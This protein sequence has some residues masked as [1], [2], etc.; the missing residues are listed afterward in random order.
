[1]SLSQELRHFPDF[2][3][4]SHSVFALP[5]ALAALLLA[6]NGHPKMRI[7]ILV[8]AALVTARTAAM[9]FNRIVDRTIDAKNPRT[10]IRHIPSGTVS[11]ITAWIIVIVST[12]LFI[13]ISF[14]INRLAGYL[15]PVALLIIF[16]Y[17]FTK[18]FTNFSH[19]VLGAALGLAPIG[20]WV[21]VL[22]NLES[23]IPWLIGLAVVLWVAGFDIIYAIQDVEFDR[24]HGL[25]SMV[26]TLGQPRALRLVGF[27]HSGM[28]VMLI[29]VGLLS[30]LGWFYF[31][32]LAIVLVSLI[33][34]QWLIRRLNQGNLQLAFL[35]ANAGASF[36][37]LIAVVMGIYL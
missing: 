12:V 31:C 3:K 11:L 20:A 32:G 1:M 25:H 27:L 4:L 21:A 16:G 23:Y 8:I 13:V 7:I 26:V 34:E 14:S 30:K 18:R 9:A 37:Y 17:S 33:W 35:Q 19:F 28:F 2:V 5:F 6:S 10:A 36:G 22:M 15:S 24:G 29:F